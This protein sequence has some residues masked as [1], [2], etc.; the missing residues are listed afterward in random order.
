MQEVRPRY[1]GIEVSAGGVEICGERVRGILQHCT[2]DTE[3]VFAA[4]GWQVCLCE[5]G[6]FH[7]C[8][9]VDALDNVG[10]TLHPAEKPWCLSDR[11][12]SAQ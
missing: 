12:K 7:V 3:I 6:G 2:A 1:L 11:S 4:R 8:W 10:C 5:C 9:I